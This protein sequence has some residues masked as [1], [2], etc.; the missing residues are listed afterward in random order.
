MAIYYDVDVCTT[1]IKEYRNGYLTN[2]DRQATYT[3]KK[4]AKD[5]ANY[6]L[7]HAENPC[8]VRIVKVKDEDEDK[9]DWQD[10]FVK[11]KEA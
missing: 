6:I 1:P 4:E 8:G 3:S 10:I 2:W 11:F 9:E 7:E 5:C